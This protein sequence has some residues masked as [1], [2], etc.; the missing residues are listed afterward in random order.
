M[1]ADHQL[2]VVPHAVFYINRKGP[3]GLPAAGV[4]GRPG[5]VIS[6][7]LVFFDNLVTYEC[8]FAH[9]ILILYLFL[10]LIWKF[11]S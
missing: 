1:F 2:A 9:F 7:T 6:H 5:M 4:P 3:G 8:S 11:G 10:H